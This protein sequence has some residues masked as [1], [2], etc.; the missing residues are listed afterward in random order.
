MP[1]RTASPQARRDAVSGSSS[2]RHS[3]AAFTRALAAITPRLKGCLTALPGTAWLPYVGGEWGTR[4]VGGIRQCRG[5]DCPN[6]GPRLAAAKASEIERTV[7]AH[8]AGGAA[9]QPFL[10][11]VTDRDGHRYDADLLSA[12]ETAESAGGSIAMITLTMRH[13]LHHPLQQSVDAATAGWKAVIDSR[14]RD[15]RAD[16]ALVD[17]KGWVRALETTHGDHGWH[18]HIH[19]LLFSELPPEELGEW[20]TEAHS[21]VD[22]VART[23]TRTTAGSVLDRMWDRWSTAVQAAGMPAPDRRYGLHALVPQNGDTAAV[24]A[25]YISKVKFADADAGVTQ[26]RDPS[27]VGWEIAGG[28]NKRGRKV[29]RNPL[30]VAADALDGDAQSYVLWQEFQ[31]VMR[32][33]RRLQWSLAAPSQGRPELRTHYGTRG[34]SEDEIFDLQHHDGGVGIAAVPRDA[35]QRLVHDRHDLLA[36]VTDCETPGALRRLLDLDPS[37]QQLPLWTL[38]QTVYGWEPGRLISAAEP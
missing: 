7:A 14:N 33:V 34:P 23:V 13:H 3:R 2:H 10:G 35:H 15:W 29:S 20:L 30:D 16:C 24:V 36:A 26:L 17:V 28:I 4:P 27:G 12:V 6:C 1:S 9:V 11:T 22:P 38:E 8:L 21:V 5:A 31:T 25:E 37:L 18:H 32:G 19:F